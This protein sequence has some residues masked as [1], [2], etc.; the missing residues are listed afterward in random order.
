[1]KRI[2]VSGLCCLVVSA[3]AEHS[4]D[5]H[6]DIERYQLWVNE[7]RAKDALSHSLLEERT[8]KY[9]RRVEAFDRQAEHFGEMFEHFEEQ[10]VYP[11]PALASEAYI[12]KDIVDLGLTGRESMRDIGRLL[13]DKFGVEGEGTQKEV[14]SITEDGANVRIVYSIE[15][16]ADDSVMG[17]QHVVEANLTAG[18]WT[19]VT[20]YGVRHKCWEGRGNTDWGITPSG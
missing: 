11:V 20:G 16:F 15:G 13:Q 6:P 5:P 4:C 12:M 9:E 7:L 18:N 19:P 3:C 8:E 1:M 17:S 10:V 14:I 2:L